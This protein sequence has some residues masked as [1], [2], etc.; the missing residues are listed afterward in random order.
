MGEAYGKAFTRSELSLHEHFSQTVEEGPQAAG[1]FMSALK[2]KMAEIQNNEKLHELFPNYEWELGPPTQPGWDHLGT[3]T[4]G[5]PLM[6]QS[7]LG[8]ESYASKVVSRMDA[9]S[10]TPFML[11]RELYAKIASERPDLAERLIDSGIE[12]TSFTADA[13]HNVTLLAENQGLDIPDDVG[14]ILPYV[15]EAILAVRLILDVVAV[16]RDLKSFPRDQKTRLQAL[17]A[18]LLLQRFGV[19]TVLT[20]GGGMV[21]A[22]GGT[23]VAPGPGSA[24]GG[25]VGSV[26][27][28]VVAAKANQMIRPHTLRFALQITGMSEDDLFYFQNKKTVDQ[29]ARDFQAT[30]LPDSVG[31]N[32]RKTNVNPEASGTAG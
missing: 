16:E 20:G 22:A 3:S 27:G 17:R 14:D 13:T 10:D 23:A 30:E 25:I 4:D 7:K 15:G 9:D 12:N 31:P 21:G 1:G 26:V 11:S 28:A 2:G 6:V 18:L 24:V 32:G 8:G 5:S 19:T 29:L